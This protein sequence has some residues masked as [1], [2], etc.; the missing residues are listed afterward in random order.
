M[1][2]HRATRDAALE[3]RGTLT[4]QQRQTLAEQL[5]ERM[6]PKGG[7]PVRAPTGKGGRA[8]AARLP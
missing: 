3:V 8:R 5:R 1:Q 7:A 6:G 4:P 2:E